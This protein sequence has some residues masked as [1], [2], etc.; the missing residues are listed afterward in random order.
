MHTPKTVLM[1]FT[2]LSLSIPPAN[3]FLFVLGAIERGK[4]YR[5]KKQSFTDVLQIG[6]LETFANS[7]E[8]TCVGVSFLIKLQV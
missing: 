6:V 1:H 3:M 2:L 5:M 8:N 7:Q 4:W